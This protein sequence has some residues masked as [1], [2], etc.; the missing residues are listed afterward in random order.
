MKTHAH[1]GMTT[2]IMLAAIVL[3]GYLWRPARADAPPNGP[4]PK[5]HD[6]GH[7]FVAY[8][9]HL[10]KPLSVAETWRVLRGLRVQL[11]R[12]A[13]PRAV[14]GFVYYAGDDLYLAAVD[15]RASEVFIDR[16]GTRQAFTLIWHQVDADFSP[17]WS[18][19]AP[20]LIESTD[21]SEPA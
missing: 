7:K 18:L 9:G 1:R 12:F 5:L 11:S 14:A 16:I 15:F 6:D 8:Y 4:V 21:P 2:A 3:A 19:R 17:T 10:D 20:D 13:A